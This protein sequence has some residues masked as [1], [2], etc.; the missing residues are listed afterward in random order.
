MQGTPMNTLRR[1]TTAAL[2]AL[3]LVSLAMSSA[4]AAP[5]NYQLVP[6]GNPG[7]ANDTTGYGGVAY[8]YQIG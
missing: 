7:N 1:L 4:H 8:D 6:V 5:I 3:M 2:V